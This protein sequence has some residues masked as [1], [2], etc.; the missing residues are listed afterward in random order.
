MDSTSL[1]D[2]YY[3]LGI[4]PESSTKEIKKAYHRLAL[5]YHPDK[6]PSYSEC[7]RFKTILEAYENLSMMHRESSMIRDITSGEYYQKEF[8]RVPQ[9]AQSNQRELTKP[10]PS[11]EDFGWHDPQDIHPEAYGNSENSFNKSDGRDIGARREEIA[12]GLDPEPQFCLRYERFDGYDDSASPI[13]QVNITRSN[14][15]LKQLSPLRALLFFARSK[16]LECVVGKLGQESG[17]VERSIDS[18]G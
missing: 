9:L 15:E 5:Q 13:Q 1:K 17:Y 16:A 2:Y 11:L 7:T 12:R 14:F 10:Y 8:H 6:N 4:E 18:T 3:V